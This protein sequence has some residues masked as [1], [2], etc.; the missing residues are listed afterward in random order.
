MSKEKHELYRNIARRTLAVFS[1]IAFLGVLLFVSAGRIDWIR[2]WFYLG[3][4][5]TV[6]LI[7]FVVLLSANPEVIAAR[8]RMGRGTKRFDKIFAILSLPLGVAIFVVAGLE[9]GRWGGDL[10]PTVAAVGI[11][12]VCLADIP[13]LSS[14]MVNRHLE[15]TVRIQSE[16]E[17]AVVTTG[18]YQYVRHPMYVGML[19]QNLGCPLLLGSQWALVPAAL[20]SVALII[21]TSL[22]DQTLQNELPGYREF[23]AQTKYRLFPGIW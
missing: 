3:L 6:M 2:A 11:V 7:N 22:E 12:L 20:A 16:R 23:A 13:I 8:A 15:K 14:M 9:A 17:H 5:T 18:A 4:T 1:T 10:G 19:L 21:R